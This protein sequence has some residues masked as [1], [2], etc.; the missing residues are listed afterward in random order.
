MDATTFTISPG[1]SE[2]YDWAFR[3]HSPSTLSDQPSQLTLKAL[4]TNGCCKAGSRFSFQ[5]EETSLVEEGSGS[6]EHQE[7]TEEDEELLDLIGIVT[8]AYAKYLK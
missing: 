1:S 3:V 7:E 8:P 5:M 4:P 6:A 2:K